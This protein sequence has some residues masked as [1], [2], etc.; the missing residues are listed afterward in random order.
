MGL[1]TYFGLTYRFLI[2]KQGVGTYTQTCGQNNVKKPDVCMLVAALINCG[3]A[4]AL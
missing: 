1:T 2:I 3:T 4:D